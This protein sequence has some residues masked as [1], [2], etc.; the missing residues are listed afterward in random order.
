MDERLNRQDRPGRFRVG[1]GALRRA[2]V[3]LAPLALFLSLLIPAGAG[4]V[5]PAED[6]TSAGETPRLVGREAGGRSFRKPGT[7]L[8][9]ARRNLAQVDPEELR[10]RKI[11]QVAHGVRFT[12]SLSAAPGDEDLAQA[13]PPRGGEETGA[14]SERSGGG[15]RTWHVLVFAVLT[16]G[17]LVAVLRLT[18]RRR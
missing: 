14:A 13:A 11:Q 1:G 10:R 6:S 4:A 8:S 7:L 5:Q 2:L 3:R 18:A 16:A 15:L 9:R 17:V 12:R